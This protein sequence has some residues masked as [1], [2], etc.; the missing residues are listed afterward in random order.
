MTEVALVALPMT[1]IIITAGIDLSVGS[2][3]GVAAIVLGYAWKNLGLPLELAIMVGIAAATLGGFFQ[4]PPD[5]AAEGAAIDHDACDT[6]TLP[7]PCRGYQPGPFG[8][9]LSGMVFRPGTGRTVRRSKPAL[10]PADRYPGFL[11][12]SGK[13]H[14]W[15]V[16]LRHRSQR[17][18]RP[19]FRH[20]GRS[21]QAPDLHGLR[22]HG[23]HRWLHLREQGQHHP[24]RTWGPASNSM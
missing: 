24:A 9:R 13:N 1:L 8:A 6:G 15:T 18:S 12:H 10:D 2:M 16:P 3:M 21:H 23:R 11:V 22:L 14:L 4:W 17:N 7:R 20:P 19:L 5:H